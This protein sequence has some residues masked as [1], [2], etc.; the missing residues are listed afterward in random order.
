MSNSDAHFVQTKFSTIR[1]TRPVWVLNY[2]AIALGCDYPILEAYFQATKGQISVFV[3]GQQASR[4]SVDY[5][6]GKK[7][8]ISRCAQQ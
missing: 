8:N 4:I 2:F 6:N 3:D 7:N 5:G 1:Y